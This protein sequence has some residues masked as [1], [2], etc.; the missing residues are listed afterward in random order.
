MGWPSAARAAMTSALNRH[1]AR[2][3]PPWYLRFFCQSPVRP[4]TETKAAGTGS[5]GT[6]PLEML[7]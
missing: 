2:S 1:T 3:G 4:S 7:T 5:L 6:P